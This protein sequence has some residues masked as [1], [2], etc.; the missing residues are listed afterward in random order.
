MRTLVVRTAECRDAACL[1]VH[2]NGGSGSANSAQMASAPPSKYVRHQPSMIGSV[3]EHAR[4]VGQGMVRVKAAALGQ[5][6]GLE[7]I[8][9]NVEILP[10][11]GTSAL[12]HAHSE[13]EELLFVVAGT[14]D[15]WLDGHL[16]RLQPGDAAGFPAGTGIAHCLINN[17]DREVEFLVVGD[18][19]GVNVSDKVI[20]PV[21]PERNHPRPWTDAPS[22]ELGLHDGQPTPPT[23]HQQFAPSSRVGSVACLCAAVSIATMATRQIGLSKIR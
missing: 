17:S 12:P 15:L 5:A 16:H 9:V 11:G 21:N 14:P 23:D 13:D 6:L 8:G 1:G 3:A 18:R 22:R 4:E 2:C 7:R 19:T 20:Y 10:P